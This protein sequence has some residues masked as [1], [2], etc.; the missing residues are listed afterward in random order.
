MAGLPAPAAMPGEKP[1]EFAALL[2]GLLGTGDAPHA[3][4]LE[5]TQAHA[6]NEMAGAT[7]EDQAVSMGIGRAEGATPTPDTPPVT[8]TPSLTVPDLLARMVQPDPIPAAREGMQMETAQV[9]AARIAVAPRDALAD[10]G[11]MSPQGATTAATVATPEVAPNRMA[12]LVP[13]GAPTATLANTANRPAAAI[14]AQPPGPITATTPAATG[15]TMADAASS[16]PAMPSDPAPTA[17]IG[18]PTP[19]AAAVIA[20]APTPAPTPAPAPARP[21]HSVAEVAP[22]VSTVA[23]AAPPA[24]EARAIP[25]APTLPA[26]A[27]QAEPGVVAPFAIPVE[28]PPGATPHDPRQPSMAEAMTSSPD[29]PPP[30]TSGGASAS[31][32]GATAPEPPTAPPRPAAPIPWPARQVVPFVVSLALGSDDGINLTLNPV[33]LGRV[34]VAIARGTE[35]HV[36]LRVE[37]PETLALLQRDRAELERALAGTGFGAEGRTPSL[38]FGLGFGGGEERRDRRAGGRSSQAG[39]PLVPNAAAT[40]AI[41]QAA[42]TAR[43]LIDL[44]F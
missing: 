41:R 43:G 38:S 27:G 18:P 37:R 26:M 13:D 12:A 10:Q 7:A 24:E 22:P 25:A 44:A 5:S 35:G 3:A 30:A 23:E 33:E 21:G 39:Q 32:P 1:T 40:P 14:S 6:M 4:P 15:D 2:E 17:T 36:S 9:E 28:S 31:L 29:T 16:V 8:P 20:S 19:G 34:E 42:P 11:M